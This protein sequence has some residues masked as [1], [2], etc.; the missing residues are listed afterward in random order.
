MAL[1][2]DVICEAT[3][4]YADTLFAENDPQVMPFQTGLLNAVVSPENTGAVN[5]ERITNRGAKKPKVKIIV[6]QRA[7]DD[8]VNEDETACFPDNGRQPEPTLANEYELDLTVADTFF[9]N[10]DDFRLMCDGDDPQRY[11]A[12]FI[13]QSMNA[14]VS[15]LNKRLI[16]SVSANFGNYWG[17]TTNS[18]TSPAALDLIAG[19]VP[20][21]GL[22]SSGYFDLVN[23]FTDIEAMRFFVVGVGDLRKAMQ[24]LE[25][26]CCNGVGADLSQLEPAMF[27]TDRNVLTTL[28]GQNFIGFQP[29]SIIIPN[30]VFNEGQ[31]GFENSLHRKFTIQHPD[32]GL[33]F[34]IDVKFDANCNVLSAWIRK[35]YTIVYPRTGMF[36]STDEMFGVNGVL[37]FNAAT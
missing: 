2:L 9:M 28:G 32:T 31:Y 25:I 22:N 20:N 29:G 11:F 1:N 30:D 26:G 16:A 23:A 4:Q 34:D 35:P 17:G 27:Y 5:I 15:K 21:E 19:S 10:K 13:Y 12:R 37:K 14:L 36:K 8:E 3:Q 18:G 24:F 7:T 33:L 6:N